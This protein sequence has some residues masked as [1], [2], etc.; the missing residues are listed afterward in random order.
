[1][2]RSSATQHMIFE[3]KKCWV[4]RVPPRCPG[5]VAPPDGGGVGAGRQEPPG[6]LVHPVELVGQ[7]RRGAQQLAGEHDGDPLRGL[8]EPPTRAWLL[9]RRLAYAGVAATCRTVAGVCRA[10]DVLFP[11]PMPDLHPSA[12]AGIPTFTGAV[13]RPPQELPVVNVSAA[14]SGRA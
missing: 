7:P 13:G 1:M 4:P 2:A 11:G 10:G 8:S 12:F 9:P 6:L 5:P 3:Q 14:W